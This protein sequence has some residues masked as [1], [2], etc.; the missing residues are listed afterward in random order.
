[1]YNEEEVKS[2]PKVSL[3]QKEQMY[4]IYTSMSYTQA[5]VGSDARLN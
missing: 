4:Q 2:H 5:L 3:C 1:M